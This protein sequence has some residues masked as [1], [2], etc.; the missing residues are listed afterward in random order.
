M[1]FSAIRK[2]PLAVALML[3]CAILPAQAG[4]FS[5]DDKPAAK[6]ESK[7]AA[8]QPAAPAANLPTTT[9]EDSI[10]EAQLL[11]LAA[12]YPEAI[13]H[14]SQLMMVAADD[15]RVISEYGK[16]LA[17]MGRASDA[18]NFLTR[19][20]QLQPGDWTI[21]SAMG[22]AYDQLGDQKNAQSA[23]EHALQIKPDE[24]SVLSN[25]ALSRM[26]AKDPDMARKLAARAESAGGASDSK[27][28]RNIAMIRSMA[29]E[30]PAP[31]KT[32]E[33]P[34]PAAHGQATSLVAKASPEAHDT[35]VV[36]QR[37]PVDPKAGPVASAKPAPADAVTHAPR[38]LQPQV[39]DAAHTETTAT[40]GQPAPKPITSQPLPP[41]IA[42]VKA[43]EL[44]PLPATMAATPAAKPATPAPLAKMA[45]PAPSKP[46][47]TATASVSLRLTPPLK[48][49]ADKPA[50][51]PKV[52]P[53][54]PVKAAAAKDAVPGLRVSTNAY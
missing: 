28:A 25:F 47:E 49:E 21:Y 33:Q 19:A 2:A 53:P 30:A 42:P 7:P 17:S 18:V 22:V 43:A 3:G 46:A 1:V 39:A 44:R 10:R 8:Q 54:T 52:L 16:T 32:A 6:A 50:Q 14:L 15:P 35:H 5:S 9:L 29:P 48:S 13:K 27:I 11:R 34:A 26:L 36:M 20:Q 38:A 45:P 51:P 4:W 23:Y 40:T 37:V 41:P 24:P 12:Q 31:V